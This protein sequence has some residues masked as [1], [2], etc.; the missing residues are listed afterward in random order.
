MAIW[1]LQ[2]QYTNK[3]INDLRIICPD[4][5]LRFD[6]AG[7]VLYQQSMSDVGCD[8]LAILQ[9]LGT[10]SVRGENSG[11]SATPKPNHTLKDIA[12]IAVCDTYPATRMVDI[13]YD[14]TGCNGKGFMTIDPGGVL[15]E[16]P[17]HV[18][19]YHELAHAALMFLGNHDA[20]NP[21]PGAI[22]AEN[23]YRKSR[24]LPLRGGHEGGCVGLF[25]PNPTASMTNNGKK[26]I[27]SICNLLLMSVP[28]GIG[29]NHTFTVSDLNPGEAT[30]KINIANQTT[31]TFTRIELFY[32]R[33]GLPGLVYLTEENFIP[34][35]TVTFVCGLCKNMESYAIAF[36]IGEDLV[37]KIPEQGSMTPARA[38]VMKPSDKDPCSD[39]WIISE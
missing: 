35:Q 9:R 30:Y 36:L 37:A 3:V 16:L 6:N 11:W 8:A 27:P 34:G 20:N 10:V 12:G 38:S 18:L 7:K 26:I 14:V 33:V 24:H 2:N 19:L 17:S 32:K 13:V 28:Q 4:P 31:D 29:T 21:E 23:I 5:N 39:S 22:A 15:I 25:T 1:I